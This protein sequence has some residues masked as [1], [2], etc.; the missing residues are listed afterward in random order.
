MFLARNSPSQNVGERG[1][2]AGGQPV[3][4]QAVS[5]SFDL[6]PAGGWQS[7]GCVIWAWLMF[8]RRHVTK[9]VDCLM[10]NR[11]DAGMHCSWKAETR[12]L[13]DTC[14][15]VLIEGIAD[16]KWVLEGLQNNTNVVPDGGVPSGQSACASNN[17]TNDTGSGAITTATTIK[18][19]VTAYNLRSVSKCSK[20]V[21]LTRIP[22][23]SLSINLGSVTRG[24]GKVWL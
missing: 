5:R 9:M 21:S 23:I 12:R 8:I 22:A 20:W 24:A 4:M 10:C 14:R 11:P 7:V 1:R 15:L 3:R 18:E 16:R 6:P 13:C 2:A 19:G 17:N